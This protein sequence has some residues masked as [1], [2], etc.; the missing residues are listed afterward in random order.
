MAEA[1]KELDD[2]AKTL[3]AVIG[4][5]KQ[6]HALW[7]QAATAY[8]EPDAFRLALQQCIMTSR[9]VTFIV[10]SHKAAIPDFDAWYGAF[11]EAWRSDAVMTWARDARNKIEK[12]GDLETLSEVRA[13][14]VAAYAHNPTT[15]WIPAINAGPEEIRRSIPAKYLDEHVKETG[16]LAIERRWVDVELPGR[17]VLDALAHVYGQ[18]AH[19]VIS[20]HRQLGAPIPAT[21]PQLGEHL[22]RDLLDDGRTRSMARPSRE[23]T[24]YV[25]VKDGTLVDGL[26]VPSK[27]DPKLSERARK[28]YGKTSDWGRLKDAKSFEDVAEVFF[29]EARG[30]MLRDSYHQTIAILFKGIVPFETISLALH[31]RRQKYMAMREIAERVRCSGADGVFLLSEGWTAKPEDLKPNQFAVDAPNRGEAL[32]LWAVNSDGVH[33]S[34][35]A[36]IHRKRIKKHKVKSLGPTR[37]ETAARIVAFAP[38]L[39]VWGRLGD[40]KLDEEEGWP[41]GY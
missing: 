33:L 1:A 20:L 36:D 15:H 8:F 34:L 9:T 28:R 27:N 21:N 11:Q 18:L 4:R 14:L 38:I 25:T 17:E 12:Q 32:L 16:L 26:M 7:G 5:L 41:P 10:Q 19:L 30:V 3:R 6:M 37:R 23:R 2:I 13:E 31:D 24:I 40:L 39:E 29:V 35:E 22:L